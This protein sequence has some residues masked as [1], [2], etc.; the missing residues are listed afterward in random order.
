MVVGAKTAEAGW[1]SPASLHDG[2]RSFDARRKRVRLR[3]RGH[4]Q[5]AGL[6]DGRAGISGAG[7][8]PV[9][10]PYTFPG[11]LRGSR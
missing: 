11:V 6:G 7:L 10:A 4:R 2:S 3:V 9:H 1:G 5:E 8:V